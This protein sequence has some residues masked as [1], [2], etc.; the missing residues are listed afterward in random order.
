MLAKLCRRESFRHE[1]A[2]SPC[3]AD[4]SVAEEPHTR[5]QRPALL[6][7]PSTSLTVLSLPNAT[8]AR[9]GNGVVK[10]YPAFE[11]QLNS[12]AIEQLRTMQA[13]CVSPPS[14]DAAWMA[15]RR[16]IGRRSKFSLGL[17]GCSTSAGCGALSPSPKCSMPHSWGRRAHD[18]LASA[19]PS[20]SVETSIFQKNSVEASFFLG[21][22]RELLP[23]R[24]HVIIVEVYSHPR[25]NP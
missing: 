7:M 20:V 1:R 13:A 21:C 8:A 12:S 22:T 6:E 16:R 15:A 5:P 10:A 25:P 19:M 9:D 3:Q 24:P 11:P 2:R 4:R 18:V 17:L 14:A 23:A